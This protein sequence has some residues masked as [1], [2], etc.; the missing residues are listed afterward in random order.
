MGTINSTKKTRWIQR[1]GTRLR[2]LGGRATLI[3]IKSGWP[4]HC[5]SDSVGPRT[6]VEGPKP[7]APASHSASVGPPRQA[8][9]AR[10]PRT[11]T[12]RRACPLVLRVCALLRPPQQQ[13]ALPAAHSRRRV[14]HDVLRVAHGVVEHAVV[15]ESSA[16]TACVCVYARDAAF[17]AAASVTAAAAAAAD[18]DDDDDY[19][20]T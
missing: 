14:V 5:H 2:S 3:V 4:A 18:G 6:Y 16:A 1:V 9:R 8:R 7:H 13:A 17:A 19:L 10:T 12:L 20:I 15:R 11:R